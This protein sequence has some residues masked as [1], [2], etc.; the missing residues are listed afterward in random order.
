MFS[1]VKMENYVDGASSFPYD[2]AAEW[3]RLTGKGWVMAGFNHY[4]REALLLPF[5]NSYILN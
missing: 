3:A 4:V 1:K 5:S 2:L